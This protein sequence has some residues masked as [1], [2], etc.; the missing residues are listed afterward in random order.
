MSLQSQ[1]R[2]ISKELSH[3]VGRGLDEDSQYQL[4]IEILRS[5]LLTYSPNDPTQQLGEIFINPTA[6]LSKNE[7]Y[8]PGVVCFCDI[9]VEDLAMHVE[10]YSPFGLSFQK[11][12]IVRNGG[13]PVNYLP[14]KT[15]VKLIRDISGERF[16]E[17]YKKAGGP[18]IEYE[19]DDFEII[20][21]SEYFDRMIIIYQRM[22]TLIK[23]LILRNSLDSNGRIDDK[24]FKDFDRLRMF[25]DFHIFSYFKFFDHRLA[26]H[27][28]DNYYFEREWRIVGSLKF[29]IEDV[30]RVFIPRK[31]AKKFR[32]DFPKF[33]GQFTFSKNDTKWKI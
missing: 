24:D 11:D 32:E 12:F 6:K 31:F 19:D 25:F 10:K 4:L 28:P 18:N 8:N 5:G 23:D 15:K 20:E 1:Q 26:D 17:L 16:L 21:N 2:Y 14:R 22:L 13:S 27:H 9:P 29:D 7:M 3:F 30:L 33:Y